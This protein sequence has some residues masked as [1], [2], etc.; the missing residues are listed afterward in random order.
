MLFDAAVVVL[1]GGCHAIRI[2]SRVEE[3]E[4]EEEERQVVVSHT[5]NVPL[6]LSPRPGLANSGTDVCV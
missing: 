4:E 2:S 5:R 3:K 1:F 6:V